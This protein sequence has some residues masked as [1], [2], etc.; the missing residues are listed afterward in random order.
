MTVTADDVVLVEGYAAQERGGPIAPWT[1]PQRSP[2]P[3]DV[4]IDVLFCG[5][6][7]TDLHVIGPWNRE[8]PVVPGHELVG[9]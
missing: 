1:Y 6:C 5:I 8:F 4:V 2:R 3:H 7:H 9:R